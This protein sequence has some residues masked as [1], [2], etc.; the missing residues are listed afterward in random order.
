[1]PHRLLTLVLVALLPTVAAAQTHDTAFWR[2]LAER[3]FAVPEGQSVDALA[4]EVSGL[5]ASPDPELRDDIAY[6][7]LAAWIYRER[8]V[9]G[10]T[11][12]AL[13]AEWTANLSSGIGERGTESV[14]RRSFSAL[15]LALLVARD[16]DAPWLERADVARL[17][18]SAL[19][20]LAAERD[21]RG[22][23]AAQGWMHSVAHTADLLKFLARSRHLP[24]AGQRAI[25]TAIAAKLDA[26]DVALTHG[27]DERLARAVV[28]LAARDDF[29]QAAF[30]S[31]LKTWAAPRA[32]GPPTP[33]SLAAGENR[34]H[35]IVSLH[36]LL[37]T[38]PR[39]TPGLAAARELVRGVLPR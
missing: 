35:V 3:R 31:W 1:M 33:A 22:F 26:V 39:N 28:S 24:V 34:K 29:D 23:D 16:N 36:A 13:M 2:S 9:S 18:E 37:T 7:G 30:G 8:S 38:D 17:L 6:T 27:E 21:V 20:Y 12:R 15:A 25:L 14:F 4:R 32:S 10:A 5:L 19:A 11:M